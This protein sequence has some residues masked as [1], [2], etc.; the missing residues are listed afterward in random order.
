MRVLLEMS[1]NHYKFGAQAFLLAARLA[2]QSTA[3]RLTYDDP[4][5]AGQ[6]LWER[7]GR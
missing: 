4:L 6:L 5:R 1:F 7:F 2:N 3:W